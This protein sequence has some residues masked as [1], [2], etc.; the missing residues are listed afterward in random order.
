M[1][2][3]VIIALTCLTLSLGLTACG[4]KNDEGKQYHWSKAHGV[5]EDCR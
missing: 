1:M 2:K 5:L 3:S 4:G